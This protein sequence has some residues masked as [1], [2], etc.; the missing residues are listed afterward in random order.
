ME[1]KTPDNSLAFFQDLKIKSE[2]YWATVELD[3]ATYGFQTQKN[4]KWNMGLSEA[5]IDAFEKEMGFQFSEGLRNYY[6]MM[7]GVDLPAINI[8][9]SSGEAPAYSHNFYAYPQDVSAIKAKIH[10]IYTA[11][12]TSE[13]A[14]AQ[15]GLSRIFPIFGHRFV[16]VDHPDEPILS[17][18]GDDIIYWTHNIS[19]LLATAIFKGQALPAAFDTATAPPSP[20]PFWLD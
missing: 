1:L 2:A 11:N 20:I 10:W 8:Y 5:S 7:N 18:Y 15:R 4:T 6:R 16:L 19:S 9:G 17:M 13:E 3:A 12:A 14:L